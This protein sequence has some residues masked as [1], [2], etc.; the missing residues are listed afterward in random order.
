MREVVLSIWG[1][2]RDTEGERQCESF[3]NVDASRVV[4]HSLTP[5]CG[6]P[7]PPNGLGEFFGP[8]QTLTMTNTIQHRG[9][10]HS[11]RAGTAAAG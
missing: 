9:P 4:G 1:T 7:A 2:Q 3:G 10:A 8:A 6:P 5:S 11:G